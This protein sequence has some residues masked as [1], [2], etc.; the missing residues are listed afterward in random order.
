MSTMNETLT[1]ALRDL[2]S[3]ANKR[4]IAW[5]NMVGSLD[6]NIPDELEV[7]LGL[8]SLAINPKTDTPPEGVV[9]GNDFGGWRVIETPVKVAGVVHRQVLLVN[10]KTGKT[11]IFTTAG[12]HSA[13]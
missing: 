1:S 2:G 13:S 4:L 8:Y 10:R 11:F 9:L 5:R 6:P 7:L 3:D 12:T